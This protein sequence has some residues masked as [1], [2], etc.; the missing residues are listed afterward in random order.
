MKIIKDETKYAQCNFCASKTN[1]F[2]ISGNGFLIVSIC[3]ICIDELIIKTNDN[4]K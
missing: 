4:T 2:K 3:K 1:I